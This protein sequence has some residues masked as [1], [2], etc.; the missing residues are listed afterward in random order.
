MSNNVRL[1]ILPPWS[2]Y[3][4][5]L[6][7]LF[8]EDTDITLSMEY[9]DYGTPSIVIKCY[10]REKVRAL[11]CL[12]PEEV[13][14]GNLRVDIEIE[15]KPSNRVFKSKKELFDT[16]F[17]GNPI[18]AYS[19]CPTE[20]GY[21]WF[22]I[23]YVVFKNKVVQFFADNLNDCHGIIS[24]LYQ[25]IAK[26]VFLNDMVTEGN[27][28]YNTDIEEEKAISVVEWLGYDNLC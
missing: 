9:F 26:D 3:F 28:F 21:E 1:K 11:Q 6:K 23:T 17:E 19:V 8:A 10:N 22:A 15:G 25:D 5:K 14:F 7:A 13:Y 18:Y 2:I 27:I 12:L 20:E 16:A 24:T 4:N